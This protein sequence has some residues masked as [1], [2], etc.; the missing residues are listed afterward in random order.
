MDIQIGKKQA[1]RPTSVSLRGM[2]A[3]V[4]I[5]RFQSLGTR[6]AHYL[7]AP[8]D[9]LYGFSKELIKLEE[10]GFIEGEKTWATGFKWSLTPLGFEK[11]SKSFCSPRL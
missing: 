6:A 4:S 11:I 5:W 1:G 3:M 9:G 2:A 8:S 7:V 10:K